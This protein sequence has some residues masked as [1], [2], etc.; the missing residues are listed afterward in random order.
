M[1]LFLLRSGKAVLVSSLFLSGASAAPPARRQSKS[2]KN[3]NPLSRF[4]AS[5]L[6][7]AGTAGATTADPMNPLFAPHQNELGSLLS[8]D[9]AMKQRFETFVEQKYNGE[10]QHRELGD[11]YNLEQRLEVFKKN[12]FNAYKRNER[13]G[14][15]VVHGITGLMDLDQTEF[16]GMLGYKGASEKEMGT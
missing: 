16:R 11:D 5:A 3:S 10:N 1:K 6:I 15:R 8:D 14:G 9:A 12:V 4:A 13:S 7:F 2:K